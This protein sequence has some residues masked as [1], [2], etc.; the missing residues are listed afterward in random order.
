MDNGSFNPANNP[1]VFGNI[2]YDLMEQLL[3]EGCWLQTAD[4]SNLLQSSTSPGQGPSP[5]SSRGLSY[6]SSFSFPCLEPSLTQAEQAV[7]SDCQN[8][9]NSSA[10]TPASVAAAALNQARNFSWEGNEL[11]RILWI[12]PKA[13]SGPSTSVG[14]RL[15][16]AV[17]QLKELNRNRDVLIQIWVPI[18]KGLKSFLT[19]AEQ[20]Y[21]HQPSSTRLV[22]YRDVSAKYEFLAD[23]DTKQ[24]LGLPGRVFLGKAPEWTPDVRF[25]RQE[26]YPR[27][28]YAHKYDVRGSIALPVFEK[29]SGD[30]LGVVEIIMTTEKFDYRPEVESVCKALEVSFFLSYF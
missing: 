29:G 14:D 11:N 26:E 20:P 3:D 1:P 18:K 7:D 2:D 25:F 17:Y 8:N 9:I 5:S 19:T 12:E 22:H 23:E 13:N 30:S 28:V 4:G 27:S 15:M 10:I 24:A 16:S 21:F 6:P